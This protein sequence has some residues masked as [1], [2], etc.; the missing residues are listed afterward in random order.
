MG[1]VAALGAA[2]AV[3]LAD[4]VIILMG[5]APKRLAAPLR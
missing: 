3:S 5:Q 4:G 1:A 2:A